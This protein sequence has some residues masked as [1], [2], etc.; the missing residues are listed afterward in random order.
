VCGHT[1]TQTPS[2]C[3]HKLPDVK[4]QLLPVNYRKN[5]NI[6]AVDITELHNITVI[7]TNTSSVC[8]SKI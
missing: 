7:D 3:E 1:H 5:R 4:V 6:K 2:T 8:L